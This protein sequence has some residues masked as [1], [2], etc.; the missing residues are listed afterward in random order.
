MKS[1]L[2]TKKFISRTNYSVVND[3]FQNI[4]IQMNVFRQTLY[5]EKCMHF[6]ISR[7]NS[8]ASC[9]LIEILSGLNRVNN[10]K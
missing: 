4:Q 2:N 6:T 10:D 5:T 1:I 7:N 8:D 9:I 3:E